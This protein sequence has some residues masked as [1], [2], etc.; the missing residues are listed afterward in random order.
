MT[1]EKS[2]VFFEINLSECV[3]ALPFSSVSAYST[4]LRISGK[5]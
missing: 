5:S 2:K 4:A 3:E 1:E